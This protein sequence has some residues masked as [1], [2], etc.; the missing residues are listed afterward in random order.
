ME[1]SRFKRA[2][3]TTVV[4][5]A[6][7][8]LTA[9]SGGGTPA[10]TSSAGASGG[11]IDMSPATINLILAPVFYEP[12]YIAQEQGYFKDQNLTV[13]IVQGGT[14]AENTAQLISGQADIAMSSA[15]AQIPAVAQ[16]I[17]L[18]S[19]LGATSSD[20]KVV[21]SGLLV[22]P[23]SSVTGPKD[24]VGKTICL[25]GLNET[26]HLGT[27]L[28]MQQ[29]G[30][31]DPLNA[32]KFVQLPLAD[33]VPKTLDGTCDISYPIGNAY[34]AGLAQGLKP[35]GEPS[36]DV[37]ALG[38]S[39]TY[40]ATKDWISSHTDIVKRFQ[41]AIEKAAD[42]GRQDNFAEI[43]KIQHEYSKTD[44]NVI[45]TQVLAGYQTDMY[46]SG[47]Q[48]TIDGMAEFKMIDHPITIQ[49]AVSS[50]APM[51]P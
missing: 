40:A 42:L 41:A 9:C 44:S 14:A 51:Q 12:V 29:A 13:N 20:P 34:A 32:A 26:T 46:T 17:P 22:R 47:W 3:F 33:L 25:Q 36:N 35:V 10:A 1:I 15:A 30:I 8:G 48:K 2:A 45:D 18:Q 49:D 11:P 31:A 38:P 23:D 43:R 7:V 4:G 19:I 27:L 21:T 6:A 39:V 5:L 24:Y 50:L 28:L 16:G 37:L